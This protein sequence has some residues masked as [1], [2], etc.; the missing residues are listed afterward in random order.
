MEKVR[1]DT[2]LRKLDQL[3]AA[4]QNQQYNIRQQLRC[5]PS[6]IKDHWEK[7]ERLLADIATPATPTAVENSR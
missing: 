1:V 6:E 7:I 2:E 4:H 3:R 5:L